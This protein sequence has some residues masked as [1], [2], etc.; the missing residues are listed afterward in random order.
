MKNRQQLVEE[1]R[2]L[3][4]KMV[5][6]PESMKALFE[7]PIVTSTPQG[8]IIAAMAV[9]AIITEVANRLEQDGEQE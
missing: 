4:I 1:L 8:A 6:C 9:N 2:S 5:H 7:H 3:Q